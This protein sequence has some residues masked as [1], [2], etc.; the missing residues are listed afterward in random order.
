MGWGWRGAWS[1]V[2][3]GDGVG[4]GVGM[5]WGWRGAWSRD[6]LRMAWGRSGD[7]QWE[8]SVDDDC[9]WSRA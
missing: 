6:G 9:G 4:R 7:V 1:R 8:W 3:L 5:G 2:G